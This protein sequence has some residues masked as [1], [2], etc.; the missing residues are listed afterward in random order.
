[1]FATDV[2]FEPFV[3][4]IPNCSEIRSVKVVVIYE[5]IRQFWS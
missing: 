3:Q 1:M 2:K 4:R 5:A